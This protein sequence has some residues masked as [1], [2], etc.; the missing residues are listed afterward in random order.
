MPDL[1]MK[2]DILAPENTKVIKFSGD[3]PS[4]VLK[5]IPSLIKETF[6]VSSTN[7]YEDRI[8]WDI[9]GDPIGFYGE[10]RGADKK[11]NKTSVWI[12]VKTQGEQT[13][14]EKKGEVTIWISGIIATKFSYSNI[15]DK[16]L[17]KI[18]SRLFYSE[19]RRRHVE[20]ARRRFIIL[21]NEIKKQ[22]GIGG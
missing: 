16:S 6:K 12:K 21:E 14:K 2:A 13:Q 8:K 9:S 17:V 7:F 4:I 5:L 15:L 20:E 18:Y 1:Q 3:H 10:W 19:Q 22:L 11:D